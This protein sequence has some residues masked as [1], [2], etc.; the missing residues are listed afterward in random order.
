MQRQRAAKKNKSSLSPLYHWYEKNKRELP[1]RKSRTAYE[2]WVSEIMLQQTR[3]AAML[4]PYEKF[5]GSFPNIET[6]AKAPL[7][8]VLAAWQGLGYY[9]RARNLHKGAKHVIEKHKGSFP[10]DL[11]SALAIPGVGPYTAAAVL[12]ISYDQ[13][14]AVLDGNVTRVLTR[15]Y[16]VPQASSPLLKERAQVLMEARGK[17][18]PGKHNQ[19]MMELGSLF[20]VP[21]DPRCPQCPLAHNCLSYQK[22]A[23]R[24]AAQIP[25]SKRE[26]FI[27]LDLKLW[28][29]FSQDQ[30]SLLILREKHSRFFK[31]LWFLPYAYKAKSPIRPRTA[32][33]FPEIISKVPVQKRQKIFQGIRHSIT[34]HKIKA[35][36]EALYLACKETEVLEFLKSC[37]KKNKKES[38]VQWLWVRRA[39][40]EKYLVSSLSHKALQAFAKHIDRNSD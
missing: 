27:E 23:I 20:C 33:R 29:V 11:K 37:H 21:K 17:I 24:E 40:V 8:K 36:I 38:E 39:Q 10:K 13:P 28:L 32:P 35:Q 31:D 30:K 7:G 2:I 34:H 26:K 4:S 18:K 3:V 16:H 5:L 1:F 15:L 6:L 25:V 12:S 9:S 22:G 14:L 19:A